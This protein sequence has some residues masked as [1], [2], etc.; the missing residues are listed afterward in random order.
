MSEATDTKKPKGKSIPGATTDEEMREKYKDIS[1]FVRCGSCGFQTH[2]S[3]TV[4][5]ECLRC[6]GKCDKVADPVGKR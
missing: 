4:G 1:Y 2:N 6:G 3:A 5:D